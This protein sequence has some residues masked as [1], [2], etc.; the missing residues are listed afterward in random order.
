MQHD[1]DGGYRE[2][3][4]AARQQRGGLEDHLPGYMNVDAP[5]AVARHRQREQ[6][7]HEPRGD[8]AP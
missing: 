5:F 2:Q 3:K 1:P 6:R 8:R 4:A 7:S